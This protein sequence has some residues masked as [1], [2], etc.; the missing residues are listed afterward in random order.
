MEVTKVLEGMLN[1]LKLDS[2]S[3]G[4]RTIPIFITILPGLLVVL[5]ILPPTSPEAFNWKSD[6]TILTALVYVFCWISAQVGG[7]FGK[8]RENILWAKWGGAPTT[9]F[10]RHDNSEYSTDARN[11]VHK[12][13]RSLGLYVPS[14]AEQ[15][16]NPQVAD[17]HYQ[18]CTLELIRLTRDKKRFPLVF[19]ALTDY[20]F[21]RNAYA[22]KFLGFAFSTLSFIGFFS[23]AIYDWGVQF[24]PTLAT[25][26]GLIN[27]VLVLLWLFWITEK[28]VKITAEQYAR[29]LLEASLELQVNDGDNSLPER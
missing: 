11:R 10:L 23:L 13:L 19:K 27:I 28:A 29:F 18:S 7:D 22:L 6:K 9:R 4:A 26:F 16:Q 25:K 2:Y 21:R 24:Q 17:D 15:E 3:L 20:G 1:A 14:R 8:R 12:K 5:L